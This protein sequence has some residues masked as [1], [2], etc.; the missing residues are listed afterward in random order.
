[1]NVRS[2]FRAWI[3]PALLA[4]RRRALGN[5]LRFE[6]VSEDW[7]EALG[8][9]S[10][11]AADLIVDRVVAATREVVAGRALFERDSV[12]FQEPDFRYPII[13]ALM[14]AA[15]LNQGRLEVVDFGGSLGSTYRQCRQFLAGLHQVRW[16]VVEQPHFV[17]VG[18]REFTTA[19]LTF[20]EAVPALPRC[21]VPRL[22]LLSSVIQY[23]ERP[24]AVLDELMALEPS[25]LV[26]DRTPMSS[27]DE[28]RLT[29]QYAPKSVYDASYPCWVLSRRSL[30]RQLATGGLQ[31][32]GEFPGPEGH[33]RTA[34][35]LNFEFRGLIAER[36]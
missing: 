34:A 22:V 7:K 26:V 6:D 1:M 17:E 2:S 21:E 27:L 13:A 28:H 5:V 23:L 36:A 31:V 29:I 12:L 16:L 25:H 32:A 4:A 20:H 8:K 3:P 11:Y 24:D 10:G 33:F 9:S 14:R 15:A 19:E 35:G 30:V 18:R